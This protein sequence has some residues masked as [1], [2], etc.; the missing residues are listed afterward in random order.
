MD[1]LDLMDGQSP[2]TGEACG[3]HLGK[4]AEPC[5]RCGQGYARHWPEVYRPKRVR[6]VIAEVCDTCAQPLDSPQHINHCRS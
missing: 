2:P 4:I 5:K 1:Q 6:G 3:Y